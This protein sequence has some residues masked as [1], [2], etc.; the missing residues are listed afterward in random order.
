MKKRT[1][2]IIIILIL[3]V[4]VVFFEWPW[5]FQMEYETQNAKDYKKCLRLVSSL[6]GV[7]EVFPKKLPASTK[8]DANDVS[9]WCYNNMGGKKLELR[10]KATDDE[11]EKQNKKMNIIKVK[12]VEEAVQEAKKHVKQGE[13]V[14]FSPASTSFDMF[15]NFEERGKKF[16]EEV[17]KL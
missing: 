7:T 3:A 13:I 2:I 5:V 15:K 8:D 17:K 1:L 12:N 4:G 16:K 11:I 6:P 14:L 9:F 10:F